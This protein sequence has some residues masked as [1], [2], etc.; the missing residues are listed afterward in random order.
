[1]L[2]C[3]RY[4]TLYMLTFSQLQHVQGEEA[5]TLLQMPPKLSLLHPD[6]FTTT[7]L[8]LP[9]NSPVLPTSSAER[10]TWINFTL[11]LI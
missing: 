11:D 10:K 3:V 5:T 4:V 9:S 1:M 2:S 8:Q 7:Y 6:L